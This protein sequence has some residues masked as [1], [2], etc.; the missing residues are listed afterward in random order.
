MQRLSARRGARTSLVLSAVV[1]L[2]ETAV[3][4][5]TL[6]SAR[7]LPASPRSSARSSPHRMRMRI[8][9]YVPVPMLN[10]EHLRAHVSVP[11][12]LPAVGRLV[13]VLN[14]AFPRSPHAWRRRSRLPDDRCG[15]TGDRHRPC[16]ALSGDRCRPAPQGRRVADAA[17]GHGGRHQHAGP[18]A[19]AGDDRG[20]GGGARAGGRRQH[21][22]TR[23]GR[24]EPDL[25]RRL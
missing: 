10:D 24:R 16:A 6:G 9:A 2:P 15:G 4:R 17:E 7:G 18:D 21:V 3:G 25:P 12:F 11:M 19:R 20:A 22:R 8:A 13:G 5:V 23:P 14:L 1:G